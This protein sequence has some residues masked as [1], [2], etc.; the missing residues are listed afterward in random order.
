[1]VLFQLIPSRYLRTETLLSQPVQIKIYCHGLQNWRNV[2]S[3]LNIPKL[4][5]E[6]KQC[7]EGEIS[8][9]EILLILDNFQNN[10]SPGSDGIPIEFYKTCWNLISDS[11]RMHKGFL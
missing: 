6:Q 11:F 8:L 9:E 3:N 1:M 2:L 7:C 5:E 4:S 10:K